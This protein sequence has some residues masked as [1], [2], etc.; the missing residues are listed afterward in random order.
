MGLGAARA[1]GSPVAVVSCT[2]EAPVNYPLHW[3]V[4][5]RSPPA[6]AHREMVFLLKGK[7]VIFWD[8]LNQES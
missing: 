4:L 1:A 3:A 8:L 6:G 5:W 2:P 7:A